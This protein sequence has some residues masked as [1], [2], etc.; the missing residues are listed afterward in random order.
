[1]K[2]INY[3]KGRLNGLNDLVV[4]LRDI[5]EK[6]EDMNTH[7]LIELLT[8]HINDQMASVIDALGSSKMPKQQKE[9]VEEMREK[10]EETKKAVQET[11]QPVKKVA[12][13]EKSIDDLLRDLEALRDSG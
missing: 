12:A 9:M 7:E 2:D 10:H 4:I 6:K 8:S 5:V 3:V 11:K 1:M 13:Q